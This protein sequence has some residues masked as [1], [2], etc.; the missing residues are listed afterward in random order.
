MPETQEILKCPRCTDA[1]GLVTI[2]GVSVDRCNACGGMYLDESE[3]KK[4]EKE[5]GAAPDALRNIKS[6]VG[7][8]VEAPVMCI[9]CSHRMDRVN[10]SYSSG[11]FIDYCPICKSIW[12]DNGELEKI[13]DYMKEG[14][15]MPEVEAKKYSDLLAGIKKTT[16]AEWEKNFRSISS[17]GVMGS[18]VNFVYRA[19]RKVIG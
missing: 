3:L 17:P 6:S 5:A 16:S 8:D 10:F 12:L 19:V 18:V 2:D 11:I 14:A 13:V 1:L 15:S 9:R 4:V 7:V